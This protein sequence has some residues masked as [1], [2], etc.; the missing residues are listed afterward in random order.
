MAGLVWLVDK[1]VQI[2][3]RRFS[4]L[5]KGDSRMK[6]PSM[7]PDMREILRGMSIASDTQDEFVTADDY[8]LQP[9]RYIDT[10]TAKNPLHGVSQPVIF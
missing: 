5:L 4:S 3:D 9:Q 2:L 10:S 8:Y 1:C 6:L 7:T